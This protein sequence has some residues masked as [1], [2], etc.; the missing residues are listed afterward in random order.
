M[1]YDFLFLCVC[2][3]MCIFLCISLQTDIHKHIH[4]PRGTTMQSLT[5]AAV[6]FVMC[7]LKF[8]EPED[9]QTS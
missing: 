5:N 9:K 2:V 6:V 8:P 1:S 3:H 7:K 4:M